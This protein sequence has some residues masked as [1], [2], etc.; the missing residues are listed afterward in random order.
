MTSGRLLPGVISMP[1][2]ASVPFDDL[3]AVL[4][5]GSPH[6]RVDLL[7]HVTDLFL[8]VA[9]RLD[10]KQI[11]AFD[12]VLVQPINKD[13]AKAPAEFSTPPRHRR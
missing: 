2:A 3:D 11:G 12:G 7:R 6:K 1:N 4:R 5:N 10:D 9:D 13:E 8:T